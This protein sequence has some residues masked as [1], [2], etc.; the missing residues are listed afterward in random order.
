MTGRERQLRY[1]AR[2]CE[3]RLDDWNAAIKCGDKI[4]AE[5]AKARYVT[6]RKTLAEIERRKDD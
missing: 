5:T 4:A 2:E 1:W 3:A 6:A